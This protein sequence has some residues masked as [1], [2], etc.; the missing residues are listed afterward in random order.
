MYMT[1][2]KTQTFDLEAR[3][4]RLDAYYTDIAAKLSERNAVLQTVLREGHS[5]L[6]NVLAAGDLEAAKTL[7]S[8]GI[9]RMMAILEEGVAARGQGSG[10]DDVTG[11]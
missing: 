9:A 4:R 1:K 5:A 10:G 11:A 6:G 3:F 7:A 8:N 2:W